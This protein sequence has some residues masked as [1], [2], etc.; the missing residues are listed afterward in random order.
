M[1]I[2]LSSSIT[3]NERINFPTDFCLTNLFTPLLIDKMY[4]FL[5]GDWMWNKFYI[6]KGKNR[7]QKPLHYKKRKIALVFMF[8]EFY[9]GAVKKT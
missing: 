9:F 1:I 5:T 4:W 6:H 2:R 3:Y 8:M 7:N